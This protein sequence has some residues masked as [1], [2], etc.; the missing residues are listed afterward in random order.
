MRSN[1]NLYGDKRTH[2]YG[3][4]FSSIPWC[5]RVIDEN[6]RKKIVRGLARYIYEEIENAKGKFNINNKHTSIAKYIYQGMEK[7]DKEKLQIAKENLPIQPKNHLHINELISDAITKGYIE[8]LT[9]SEPWH[10]K[11][12]FENESPDTFP[13]QHRTAVVYTGKDKYIFFSQEVCDYLADKKDHDSLFRHKSIL[14]IGKLKTGNKHGEVS[15]NNSGLSEGVFCNAALSAHP[16]NKYLG[17]VEKYHGEKMYQQGVVLEI[18]V[19]TQYLTV[20]HRKNGDHEINSVKQSRE[21]FSSPEKMKKAFGRDKPRTGMDFEFIISRNVP[22]NWITR[23]LG[24]GTVQE[25]L[26]FNF[27]EYGRIYQM[28]LP[29]VSQLYAR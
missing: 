9:L 3:E 21:Y 1:Q 20:A 13:H 17:G 6:N 5:E 29:G 23:G 24:C 22:L 16:T 15:E 12:F 2:S 18:Q 26:P 8:D 27:H 28:A 7:E 10:P 4:E 11:T 25:R 14:S 19:P